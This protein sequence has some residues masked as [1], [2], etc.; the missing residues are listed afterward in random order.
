MDPGRRGVIPARDL[1]NILVKWGERLSPREVD[2]VRKKTLLSAAKPRPWN[3]CSYW[4][5]CGDHFQFQFFSRYENLYKI[6]FED[7]MQ[8][9]GTL[10]PIWCPKIGKNQFQILSN[11]VFLAILTFK[12]TSKFKFDLIRSTQFGGALSFQS[13]IF[14]QPEHS[15]CLKFDFKSFFKK[16]P[17]AS[18]TFA[19]YPNIVKLKKLR[20]IPPQTFWTESVLVFYVH[21][22]LYSGQSCFFLLLHAKIYSPLLLL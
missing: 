19:R 21:G 9:L 1:R 11:F 22:R 4:W 7:T 20:Q 16:I 5:W 10:W 17:I 13:M 14:F 8:K 18:K 6:R 12:I 3:C 15:F 2:Q